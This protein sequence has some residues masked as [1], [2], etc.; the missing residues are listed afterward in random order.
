VSVVG[1][2]LYLSFSGS[3][4]AKELRVDGFVIGIYCESFCVCFDGLLIFSLPEGVVALLLLRFE[5]SYLAV[6]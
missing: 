2:F 6:K 4:I 3:S 1:F 5:S